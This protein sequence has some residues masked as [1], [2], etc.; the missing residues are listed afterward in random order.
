[1]SLVD[2]ALATRRFGL[3]AKKGEILKISSDA[4]GFLVS[5]LSNRDA[6]M[7]SGAGLLASGDAMAKL[8]AIRRE[9]RVARRA[10]PEKAPAMDGQQAEVTAK[11]GV[12]VMAK[13]LPGP[14]RELR[15]ATFIAEQIRRIEHAIATDAALVERLVLFWSNHFCVSG[16]KDG[17]VRVSAGAYEREAIRPHVLGRFRDMLRAVEQHPTMLVYLDNHRSIGPNSRA[18]K[19]RGRGLNENLAREILELHTLGV[20]GGYAQSDVTNLARIITGWTVGGSGQGEGVAGRFQFAAARHEP[21]DWRVLGKVYREEG[22]AAG[23]RVLDDLAR[24]PATARHV[25]RKLVQ[26]FVGDT[27]PQSLVERLARIFRDTDGDLREVVRGL[28]GS[29]ESWSE[30]GQKIVPPYDFMV[31]LMRGFNLNEEPRRLIRL[32]AAL[33]QPIWQPPSPKGWPDHDRAWMGPAAIRERLRIAEREAGRIAGAHDPRVLGE[34]LLGPLLS[35]E[36]RQ[37]IAR[38]ESRVQGVK[39]LIMSPAFQK[40]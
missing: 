34:D 23:E 14:E 18:G 32:A 25:A 13:A 30:E 36:E 29:A 28:A 9:R 16:T 37:A 3:G 12:G 5:S 17:L 38:A 27:A 20:D 2:A 24:H 6:G 40:R 22:V 19:K 21:G 26:H 11:D 15:Q 8:M 33:G 1:M 4:R 10:Q 39:L 35:K 31:A 7:V